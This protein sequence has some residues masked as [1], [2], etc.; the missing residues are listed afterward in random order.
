MRK[1]IIRF[2]LILFFF[3][4]VSFSQSQSGIV[5][6]LVT[7]SLT[8]LPVQNLA[9]FI[10]FT[11]KGTTTNSKGEYTLDQLPAGSY[12]LM[13]RHVAYRTVTKFITV[14]ENKSTVLDLIVSESD[15]KIEEVVKLGGKADWEQ[16]LMIFKKYFLGDTQ[17]T[18]CQIKNP[19]DLVFYYDGD[20]LMAQARQPLEVVNRYLGYEITYFLDYFKFYKVKTPKNN[21]KEQ[22]DSKAGDG[23]VAMER[24]R[25]AWS[26]SMNTSFTQ[27]FH[28]FSGSAFYKDLVLEH[29]VRGLNWKLNREA[30]FSGSLTHFLIKL[31]HDTLIDRRYQLRQSWNKKEGFQKN[32]QMSSAMLKI[33]FLGDLD[34]ILIWDPDHLRP[35]YI[36]YHANKEYQIKGDQIRTG[37]Q[38][39]QKILLL[40]DT[41]LFFYDTENTTDLKDDRIAEMSVK[42]GQLIFNSEGNYLAPYGS[43][44]WVYHDNRIQ[45]K[46]L[47]PKDYLPKEDS[48]QNVP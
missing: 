2:G 36:Y 16:S 29:P 38:P 10:P 37:P 5:R 22:P 19:R 3:P 40:Q 25:M 26:S 41:L 23:Q 14:E 15:F 44:L 12:N 33:N 46:F 39:G 17:G 1:L 28:A 18:S 21:Q 27:Y 48:I 43:R 30:E 20:I 47:L 32:E 13:F 45:L 7:D 34:S 6:G 31:Y 11:S 9:V 42:D 35:T 4:A 8:G 24:F